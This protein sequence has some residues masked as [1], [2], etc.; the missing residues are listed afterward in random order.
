ML[1]NRKGITLR[2]AGADRTIVDV[3]AGPIILMDGLSGDN[4]KMYRITGFTFRNAPSQ[5]VIWLYGAGTMN[6]LRIDHNNFSNFATGAIAVMLGTVEPRLAGKFFGVLDHNVF[7]GDN[8]FVGLKYLGPA[9]P[10]KWRLALRGTSQNMFVEDNTFRFA[11]LHDPGQGCVDTW[12]AGAV[13]FRYNDV[14]NCS[15]AAHGT[16]HNS[17]V[18]FELYKNTLQRTNASGGIWD[19]GYRLFQHQGSGEIII[20]DNKLRAVEPIT[21]GAIAIRHYRSAAP[22]VAGYSASLGRCDGAQARD[23]NFAPTEKYF[24]YPCWMQPGRAPAGG[25]PA[26]GTL[27]PVYAWMNVDQRT[28]AKVPVVIEN[29]WNATNPSVNDHIKADRDYYDAVSSQHQ[30]SRTSPFDGASGIGFGPLA[31]RPADCTTSSL[32]TG[33]GVGYWAI[34]TSTLYRCSETNVWTAHYQPYAYPHPLRDLAR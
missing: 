9:D 18:N 21:H 7:V 22:H 2:G 27:S 5:I 16:S 34:D 26:Y 11:K 4:V 12:N 20:W 19:R 24:G 3:T 31:N 6:K 17:T 25:S 15:I 29:P 10:A 14:V 28:G 1:T 32:E 23:G 8:N 33:G 30:T 13:V